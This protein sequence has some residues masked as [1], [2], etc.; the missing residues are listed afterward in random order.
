[1]YKTIIEM[2]RRQ[3]VDILV[4]Q[5]EDIKRPWMDR[6]R[7][8][9]IRDDGELL[10]NNFKVPTMEQLTAVL[11]PVHLKDEKHTRDVQ[12]LQ[13][14]LT[15]KGFV[16]PAFLGGIERA[17]ELLVSLRKSCCEKVI[18]ITLLG[19]EL[20]FFCLGI[21]TTA[22]NVFGSIKKGIDGKRQ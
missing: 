14:Q 6:L 22:R 21:Y 1:M 4:A 19:K 16:L 13:K 18:K 10:W 9:S 20:S 5:S 11:N 12:T 7:L 15:D 3:R 17:V 2:K 8:F